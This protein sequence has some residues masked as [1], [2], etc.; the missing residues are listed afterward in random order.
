[1]TKTYNGYVTKIRKDFL[2]ILER[3]GVY[4]SQLLEELA[5]KSNEYTCTPF[6]LWL[7]NRAPDNETVLRDP[8]PIASSLGYVTSNVDFLWRN[9]KTGLWMLLEEKR[10]KA[11]VSWPQQQIFKVIHQACADTPG[12]K[13]FH[14]LTFENTSPEDGMIWLNNLEITKADLLNF[15]HFKPSM[16]DIYQIWKGVK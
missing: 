7:R 8:D 2:E 3:Y 15:L 13:G 4:N 10:H 5:N 9:Y 14:L 12:Y 6:S 16:S 1:M 11:T